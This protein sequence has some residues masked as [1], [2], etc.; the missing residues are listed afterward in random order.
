MRADVKRFPAVSVYQNMSP[1]MPAPK[2]AGLLRHMSFLGHTL[3]PFLV[4]LFLAGLVVFLGGSNYLA[5]PR[6]KSLF[7]SLAPYQILSALQRFV[8]YFTPGLQAMALFAVITAIWVLFRKENPSAPYVFV[9]L[10]LF[11]IIETAM[12]AYLAL[13]P[14]GGLGPAIRM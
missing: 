8:V 1:P 5:I 4:R 9:A 14:G 6:F 13:H 10:F 3:R 2:S 11:L 12:L 7:L